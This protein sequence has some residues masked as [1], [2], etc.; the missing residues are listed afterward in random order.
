VPS[1]NEA[2]LNNLNGPVSGQ[3]AF[4][5]R[6]ICE[7]GNWTLLC[8]KDAYDRL[9]IQIGPDWWFPILGGGKAT[10]HAYLPLWGHPRSSIRLSSWFMPLGAE[11]LKALKLYDIDGDMQIS[12]DE[13]MNRL[14]VAASMHEFNMKWFATEVQMN[15]CRIVNSHIHLNHS[16]WWFDKLDRTFNGVWTKSSTGSA[17]YVNYTSET[18]P[19]S[20]RKMMIAMLTSTLSH[21]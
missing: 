3:R 9:D 1:I 13:F 6:C 8:R 5:N 18:S 4:A 14:R 15:P 12:F 16:L 19:D 7:Y 17:Q 11:N 20:C 21:R 10:A 2:T